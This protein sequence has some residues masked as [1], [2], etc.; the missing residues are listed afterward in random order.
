METE[1]EL[2]NEE[3]A[4]AVATIKDSQDAQT[5]V[6]QA[7]KFPEAPTHFERPV[8]AEFDDNICADYLERIR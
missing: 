8:T 6:A 7:L 2:R 1:T 4:E 5:A 3:H